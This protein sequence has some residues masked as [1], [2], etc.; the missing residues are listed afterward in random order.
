M[1][2]TFHETLTENQI[3]T[4]ENQKW[5]YGIL[6]ENGRWSQDEASKVLNWLWKQYDYSLGCYENN[7]GLKEIDGDIYTEME[8]GVIPLG[9]SYD[10]LMD[11]LDDLLN[12]LNDNHE[13]TEDDHGV[14]M[15]A[16]L[17]K[18]FCE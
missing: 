6:N 13:E 12:E 8:N 3:L 9:Y 14:N 7:H 11:E 18:F 10:G 1:P 16:I 4:P 2:I 17:E 5:V 15:D